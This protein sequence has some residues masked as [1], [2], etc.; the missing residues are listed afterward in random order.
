MNTRTGTAAFAIRTKDAK[1][2]KRNDATVRDDGW[3]LWNVPV[4]DLRV[5]TF[6]GNDH[7]EYTL[8]D[9]PRDFPTVHV[10]CP[11]VFIPDTARTLGAN[12]E[13]SE[14]SKRAHAE[15]EAWKRSVGL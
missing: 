4:A 14:R 3:V 6:C 9:K 7:I 2:I 1:W 5:M 15:T 8:T 12:P 10:A 11:A 13:L